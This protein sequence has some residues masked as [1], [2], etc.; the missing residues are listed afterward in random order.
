MCHICLPPW[1]SARGPTLESTKE[2]L[3]RLQPGCPRCRDPAKRDAVE[4]IRK[5]N[6]GLLEWILLNGARSGRG[7]VDLAVWR[8]DHAVEGQIWQYMVSGCRAKNFGVTEFLNPKDHD[9]PIQ[10]VIIDLTDGG[11]DYSFECIGNVG[12][13]RSGL[14]CCHKGWGTSVIVGVAA[15]GQ[16][17]S[18]RPFQLVTGRVWKGTAF[19]GF[20]SRSQVPWLVEKYM[21]KL[22]ELHFFVLRN[23]IL[24]REEIDPL[25]QLQLLLEKEVSVGEAV[26]TDLV[27]TPDRGLASSSTPAAEPKGK[28]VEGIPADPDTCP[29]DAGTPPVRVDSPQVGSHF[30]AATDSRAKSLTPTFGTTGLGLPPSNSPAR[31]HKGKEVEYIPI[32]TFELV[33]SPGTYLPGRGKT[34][35]SAPARPLQGQPSSSHHPH[36]Q[37]AFASHG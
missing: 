20:K 5:G 1:S 26:H 6:K 30:Q 28:G 24:E 7:K 35:V 29:G 19:G 16:E 27:P 10:Q 31:G 9:K 2:A 21:R 13:M 22:K 18:T 12:V 3:S 11:V 25:I 34:L 8:H 36:L 23:E 14:E 33:T 37:G 15:S 17:I 4:T 32:P